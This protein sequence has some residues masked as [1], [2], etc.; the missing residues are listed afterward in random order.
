MVHEIKTMSVD[1]IGHFKSCMAD[2]R[3][4]YLLQLVHVHAGTPSQAFVHH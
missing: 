4:Q 1:R 3:L 2:N